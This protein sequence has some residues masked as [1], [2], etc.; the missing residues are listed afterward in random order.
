KHDPEKVK[1]AINFNKEIG[2]T[3]RLSIPFTSGGDIKGFIFRTTDKDR[4]R[5]KYLNSTGIKRGEGFFNISALKGDKDLIVVE[6]YLD[7]LI[8][9]AKGVDNIVAL[10]G[11]KVTDK[12]V[13]DAIQRGAKSFTLCLDTDTAGKSGILQT[14]TTILSKGVSKIYVATLPSEEGVKTDP[15]SFIREYGVE[16]FRNQIAQAIP[17]YEY[18][19]NLLLDKY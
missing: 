8:A 18:K 19:L 7:A 14:I 15:D 9:E 12:Q 13:E 5:G 10:G 11:A 16:E 3:H 1:E 4:Q 6:G 17:Y 2:E